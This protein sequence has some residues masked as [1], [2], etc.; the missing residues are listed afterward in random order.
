LFFAGVVAVILALIGVAVLSAARTALFDGVN[1]DLES[2]AQREL[3]PLAERPLASGQLPDTPVPPGLTA[4]GYFFAFVLRDGTLLRKS[5]NVDEEGLAGASDIAKALDE[6]PLFV[7]TKSSSGEHLRLYLLALKPP[8]RP[9]LVVEVGRSTEPE[10]Q[11]LRRL[12]LILA[13]GAVAGLALSVAGGYFL[14]GRALRPIKAAM[15]KQ[16]EFV[17]DASHEL[18]TPLSLIRANAEILKRE[19]DKPVSV[20]SESVDDIISETDRLAN[21]VGQ[22]LTLARAD[23]GRARI[24][25][26]PVDLAGMVRDT[27]REMRLLA[28]DRGI[29]VEAQAPPSVIVEGD[30]LRLRELLTI[31]IDNSLKYSEEGARVDV[32]LAQ[33]NGMAVLQVRDTGRGIP[34]EALP[35]IFERF[36]R[37]DKA[38]SRELG[39]T[40]LGLAIAKWIVDMHHGNIGIQSEVGRGTTVTVELP[41]VNA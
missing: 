25:T 37:A 1:D 27:A 18:R 34:E 36:Y 17:A 39:G 4:G 6:G 38:R 12:G 31:L 5:D 11:A 28:S 35:R 19:A 3:R 13:G 30:G 21:L 16:Q 8:R 20:N 32:A 33:R 9:A 24:E 7:D 40:G 2:R 23:S 15:D 26:T 29:V 41:V 22:M 14:A 10:R